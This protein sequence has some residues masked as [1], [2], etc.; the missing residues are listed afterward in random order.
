MMYASSL[1]KY[2]ECLEAFEQD[3]TVQNYKNFYNH[4][5]SEYLNRPEKWALYARASMPTHGNHTNN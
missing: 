5:E 1:E 4:I 3:E 2:N